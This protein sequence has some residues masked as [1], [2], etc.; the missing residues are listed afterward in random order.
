VHQ[1]VT[2]AEHDAIGFDDAG[3]INA[4]GI[5][6][7]DERQILRHAQPAGEVPA[8][9]VRTQQDDVEPI[10]GFAHRSGRHLRL[11]ALAH[12]SG[13]LRERKLPHVDRQRV[14]IGADQVELGRDR[15]GHEGKQ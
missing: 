15:R 11:Q 1:P 9:L 6:R 12:N 4:D 14:D 13:D 10:D 8:S 5:D 3:R 7:P 2:A